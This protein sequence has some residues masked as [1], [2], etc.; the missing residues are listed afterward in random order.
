MTDHSSRRIP[1][2]AA[3]SADE[4]TCQAPAVAMHFTITGEVH[5]CCQNGAYEFGD[6]RSQ[7]LDEIWDGSARRAM[8]AALDGGQYPLGCEG[9][10]VEHALGNRAVTPAPPFDRFAPG[11]HRWPRQLEF[12]LSNR[13]NLACLHCN[14]DNSSTIRSKR[15]N[16]PPLPVVYED[17]F[18]EE[19]EPFLDHVEVC[20][21]LGGEPFLTPEAFRVWD[22]LTAL[23]R[24]PIVQ[25][26][27]NA[28]VWSERIE[29]LVRSCG[30][31]SPSRSTAQRGRPTRRSGWAVAGT[32]SPRSETACSQSPVSTAVAPT[33]TSACCGTTGTNWG[34]SWRN[35]DQLDVDVNVIPVWGPAEHSVFALDRSELGPLV[36]D[37][38]RESPQ[39]ASL[40]RN[41]AAW[42]AP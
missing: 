9:C 28:T 35:G 22:M 40:G 16:R 38:R 8:A 12:T 29:R 24:P 10:V 5:A 11:D 31:T 27:T 25:V 32:A 13:C 1:V 23:E 30:W 33:S 3:R 41:R 26:T 42:R 34:C 37:L 21:F 4:R 14:G 15:E 17:R 36:S 2:S 7:S 6:V 39:R 19:L 18:F 20:A